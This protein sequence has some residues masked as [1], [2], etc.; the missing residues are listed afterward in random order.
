[1]S[2]ASTVN[3]HKTLELRHGALSMLLD[4]FNDPDE[5]LNLQD[6]E[7][8]TAL[9]YACVQNDLVG[10]QL[11]LSK[12]VDSN[13]ENARGL[14]CLDY[15]I[16]NLTSSAWK[17]ATA[18][19]TFHADAGKIVDLL[20]TKAARFGA[21]KI[22]DMLCC[23]IQCPFSQLTVIHQLKI[24]LQATAMR[25]VPLSWWGS[26]REALDKMHHPRCPRVNEGKVEYDAKSIVAMIQALPRE[27]P[28]FWNTTT[29]NL[30]RFEGSKTGGWVRE[31]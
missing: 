9:H 28:C 8:Y 7:G 5:H 13:V 25:F 20:L 23:A 3:E 2:G 18:D 15:A 27:A 29:G 21:W 6:S 19:V 10:C 24:I 31:Y 17:T 16:N 14:R 4:I 12:D 22:E 1:V 26:T 11:L 30:E